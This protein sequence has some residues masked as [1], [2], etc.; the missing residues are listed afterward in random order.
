MKY[1][2][3]VNQ[4]EAN[5]VFKILM[6]YYTYQSSFERFPYEMMKFPAKLF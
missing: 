2:R 5:C 3:G 4:D 6:L 1:M